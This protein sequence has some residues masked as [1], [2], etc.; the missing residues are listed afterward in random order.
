MSFPKIDLAYAP[1]QGPTVRPSVRSE[2]WKFFLVLVRSQVL[3]FFSVR[4]QPV[5]VRGSLHRKLAD[6]CSKSQSGQCSLCSKVD[7]IQRKRLKGFQFRWLKIK[8][9]YSYFPIS[10]V[11][12]LNHQNKTRLRKC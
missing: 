9:I 12:F 8:G 10:I 3:K 1:E 5:L 4:N 6:K 7:E 2:I 11:L